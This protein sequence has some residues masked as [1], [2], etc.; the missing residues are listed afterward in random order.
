[1]REYILEKGY[2]VDADV[3]CAH[4]DSNGWKVGWNP[5]KDWKRA[6]VTWEKRRQEDK[7]RQQYEEPQGYRYK[8]FTDDGF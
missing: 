1:M 8:R 4:Y 3:F 2:H 6:L 7:P 5:M